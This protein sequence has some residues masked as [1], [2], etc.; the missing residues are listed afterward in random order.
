[1]F[2]INRNRG[3]GRELHVSNESP[4]VSVARRPKA[5][6]FTPKRT[7]YFVTCETLQLLFASHTLFDKLVDR[8]V[9]SLLEAIG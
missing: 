2:M 4:M 6:S 8:F 7:E 3:K 1:M 9:A 5:K